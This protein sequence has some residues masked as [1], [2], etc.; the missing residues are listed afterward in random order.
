[1]AVVVLVDA[2]FLAALRL[3]SGWAL[4]QWLDLQGVLSP[5]LQ[6]LLSAYLLASGLL[7]AL[8]RLPLLLQPSVHRQVLLAAPVLD[9]LLAAALL[10]QLPGQPLAALLIPAA[11]LLAALQRWGGFVLLVEGFVL[12]L[13][14]LGQA[15]LSGTL[16]GSPAQP[17]HFFA[18][19]LSLLAIALAH[20]RVEQPLAVPAPTWP[21][22][23]ATADGLTV[24]E[25]AVSH[26]LPLHVRN[27]LPLS[28]LM[29]QSVDAQSC[30]ALRDLL[31]QRLRRSDLCVQLDD[32]HLAVLLPDTPEEGAQQL[33][34]QLAEQAPQTHR[35]VCQLPPEG[36]AIGVV[37]NRL[38]QSLQHYPAH[39]DRRA[40]VVRIQPSDLN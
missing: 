38:A 26:L 33:A 32:R 13:L 19:A 28:L 2:F 35:V 5:A 29:T 22:H 34:Q 17:V 23:A 25:Q 36:V 30:A 7:L 11:L 20:Q 8:V 14:A 15:Y 27:Q 9:G 16:P 10:M 12:L 18:T 31:L 4:W 21:G 1:M 39:A 3:G 6:A 40:G 24:L 37:V